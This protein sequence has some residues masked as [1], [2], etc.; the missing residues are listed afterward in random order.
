MRKNK[1]ND[2]LELE[3][4]RQIY[5]YILKNPGLHFREL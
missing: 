1:R 4:R 3:T 5:N 2:F